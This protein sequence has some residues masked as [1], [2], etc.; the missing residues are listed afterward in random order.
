MTNSKSLA[1]CQMLPEAAG[2]YQNFSVTV[3]ISIKS[4]R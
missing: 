1:Y 2:R 4:L 3:F